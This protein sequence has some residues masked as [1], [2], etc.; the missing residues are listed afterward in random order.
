MLSEKCLNNGRNSSHGVKTIGWTGP[1]MSGKK[2]LI[3][4]DKS[5]RCLVS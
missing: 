2:G 4:N 3:S 5:E 1:Q